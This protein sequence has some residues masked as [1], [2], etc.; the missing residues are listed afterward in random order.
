[1]RSYLGTLGR[2]AL[3]AMLVF[4]LPH[5]GSA[6]RT[7]KMASITS[8]A[9]D[10]ATYTRV[11]MPLLP[12]TVSG[13][14]YYVSCNGSDANPGTIA[15]PWRTLRWV[16]GSPWPAGTTISLQAG[17][18][19]TQDMLQVRGAGTALEPIIVNSYGSGAQ[20]IVSGAG[21]T[22]TSPINL[23][24]DYS[25]LTGISVVG[26]SQSGIQT[27]GNHD[28]VYNDTI[29]N[30]GTGIRIAGTNSLIDTVTAENLK[31]IQDT[32]AP[33]D[34]YGA[35]GFN[36]QAPGAEIRNSNCINCRAPSD[37]Y[38]HDGGFVEIFNEGDNL[39]VHDNYGYNDE[40]FMEVGGRGN[41]TGSAQNV[42]ISHNTMYDVYGAFYFHANDDH[43]LPNQSVT[44]FNNTFVNDMPTDEAMLG[45]SVATLQFM[46]NT[47]TTTG[48]RVA[49]ATPELHEGNSYSLPNQ[50]LLGFALANREKCTC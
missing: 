43:A 17:C 48:Q 32:P 7:T 21:S 39:Y 8:P 30:S 6:G 44:V 19:W 49:Y 37:D 9:Q 10:A 31:M 35:V 40:G 33:G 13:A 12:S 15:A 27:F 23:V 47:V 1:M 36:V 34:D 11:S 22:Y 26:A 25:V 14:H 5:G 50:D 16:S 41:G 4:G 3:A 28:E 38:G 2:S 45:G 24:A 42:L 20:P 46:D 18:T 29:S